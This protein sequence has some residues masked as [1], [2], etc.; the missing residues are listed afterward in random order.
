MSE[1][2]VD[3]EKLQDSLYGIFGVVLRLTDDKHLINYVQKKLDSIAEI[4]KAFIETI[5]TK[6]TKQ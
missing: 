4:I 2:E 1:K 5:E 3:T 6:E